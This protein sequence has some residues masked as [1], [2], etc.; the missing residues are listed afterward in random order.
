MSTKDEDVITMVPVE[1]E[2]SGTRVTMVAKVLEQL[3]DAGP[4]EPVPFDELCEGAAIIHN[5]Q[6]SAVQLALAGMEM[7]GG[8]ERWEYVER[9]EVRPRPAYALSAKVKVK[10]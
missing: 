8:I 4:G 3:I 1:R 6:Q 2:L 5:G 7:I 10:R 9:G